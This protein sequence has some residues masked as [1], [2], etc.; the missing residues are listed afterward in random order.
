[1]SVQTVAWALQAVCKSLEE[2]LHFQHLFYGLTLL[3][4]KSC[5][6][7]TAPGKQG[8]EQLDATSS[9]VARL[10]QPMG[11]VEFSK[12]NARHEAL[13]LRVPVRKLALLCEAVQGDP[14]LRSSALLNSEACNSPPN[15]VW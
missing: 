9:E 7:R 2:R 10:E 12:G 3:L 6:C 15:T 5:C 11:L 13:Q 4:I 8:A 14:H 1:M